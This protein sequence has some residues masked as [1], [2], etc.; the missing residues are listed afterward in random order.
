MSISNTLKGPKSGVGGHQVCSGAV[1]NE[2]DEQ[3][4]EFTMLHSKS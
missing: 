3:C 4:L 1:L 2:T